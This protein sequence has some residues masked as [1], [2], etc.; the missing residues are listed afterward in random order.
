MIQK[1]LSAEVGGNPEDFEVAPHKPEG[2]EAFGA[3]AVSEM[4]AKERQ[5]SRKS[6]LMW[7][8]ARRAELRSGNDLAIPTDKRDRSG[9][10]R[11]LPF[12]GIIINGA[13]VYAVQNRKIYK[14][15]KRQISL[16]DVPEKI[17][18][19]EKR[20]PKGE[21]LPAGTIKA[22]EEIKGMLVVGDQEILDNDPMRC[23]VCIEFQA[24]S[25]LDLM[26][27][28]RKKHPKELDELVEGLEK[29]RAEEEEAKERPLP[30][31]MAPPPPQRKQTF[32]HA[33]GA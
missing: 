8:E 33:A 21:V 23:K 13:I 17:E 29:I 11:R 5:K 18:I 26:A 1:D 7:D 3:R 28:Y 6:V 20:Y 19:P 24:R 4:L 25:D 9:F 31:Q 14:G 12:K 22:R 27:H 2:M 32:R 15:G 10:D 16:K 30:E